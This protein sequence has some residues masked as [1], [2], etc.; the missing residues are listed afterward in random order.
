MSFHDRTPMLLEPREPPAA[1][2]HARKN[3]VRRS[4]FGVCAE[5][6]RSLRR[7]IDD[8]LGRGDRD[9]STLTALSQ[10]IGGMRRRI[11]EGLHRRREARRKSRSHAQAERLAT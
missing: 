11:R 3:R 2:R 9:Y 5:R 1:R 4:W 10:E 8:M 6:Y 7:R